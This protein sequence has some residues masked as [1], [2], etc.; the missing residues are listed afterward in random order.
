MKKVHL[1]VSVSVAVECVID[2][3]SKKFVVQG[4]V[5]SQGENLIESRH[6]LRLDVSWLN[7]GGSVIKDELDVVE[8]G[9]VEGFHALQEHFVLCEFNVF[10]AF[11]WGHAPAKKALAEAELLVVGD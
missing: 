3:F 4:I 7:G 1:N 8:I 5:E 6:N 9:L 10:H 2:I 11:G